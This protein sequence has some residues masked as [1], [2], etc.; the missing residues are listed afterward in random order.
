MKVTPVKKKFGRYKPGDVFEMPDRSARVF[1]R[2][3]HL[4][5]VAAVVAEPEPAAALPKPE[6]VEV[7]EVTH[8]DIA[9]Q[10]EISPRTGR[11]KR[12][13]TRRDMTAEG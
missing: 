5:E 10:V 7:S 9:E 13:Y 8:N 6:V 2:V 4:R 12:P 1:V 11:P 3:G